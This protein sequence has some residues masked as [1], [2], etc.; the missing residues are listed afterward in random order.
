MKRAMHVRMQSWNWKWRKDEQNDEL[1]EH[2]ICNGEQN[3]ELEQRKIF[4]G[5]QND[6]PIQH[7][8]ASRRDDTMK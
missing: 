8:D 3:D 4:D 5:E 1:K 7:K 2:K 6:E